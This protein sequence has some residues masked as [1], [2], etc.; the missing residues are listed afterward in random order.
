MKGWAVLT[1]IGTQTAYE[2][3]SSMLLL[4]THHIIYMIVELHDDCS[5]VKYKV[6]Y[7]DLYNVTSYCANFFN[8]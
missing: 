6:N 4:K 7:S 1:K 3:S 2:L 8:V 5:V